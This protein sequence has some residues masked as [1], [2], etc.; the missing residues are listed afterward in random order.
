MALLV[1]VGRFELPA[2][3]SQSGKTDV[4]VRVVL[5]RFVLERSDLAGV[6]SAQTDTER[7]G[8]HSP[9]LPELIHRSYIAAVFQRERPS[10]ASKRSLQRELEP[11]L[12]E[13]RDDEVAEVRVVC[14]IFVRERCVVRRHH[15]R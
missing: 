2:S 14:K 12:R 4:S 7:T 9:V 11:A 15:L 8:R 13:F 5:Y 3:C 1:G 10:A 6:M